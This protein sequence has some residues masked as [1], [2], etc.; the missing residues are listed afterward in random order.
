MDARL[1]RTDV[2]KCTATRTLIA[3]L[4]RCWSD[5][6]FL[7]SLTHRFVRLSLQLIA[8]YSTW[9]RIGLAGDW[10]SVSDAIEN[11][12]ALVIY[13]INMIQKRLPAKLASI[14][15]SRCS[16]LSTDMIEMIENGFLDAVTRYSSVIPDIAESIADALALKCKES[17]Q[18]LRGIVATYRLKSKQAP[19]KHSSFVP[20]ILCP[21]R[22]FVKLNESNLVSSDQSSDIKVSS[23]IAGKVI[24]SVAAEYLT[25]ATE[26][27]EKNKNNEATLRRLNIGRA[28]AANKNKSEAQGMS[29]VE[30]IVL[31]L[32]LD[33]EQFAE[34]VTSVGVDPESIES[35]QKL[36]D[37]IKSEKD[38]TQHQAPCEQQQQHQQSQSQP[39]KVEQ[40][41]E[42]DE[43]I[44]EDASTAAAPSSN[45]VS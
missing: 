43:N 5:D 8:R 21:L 44:N 32:F 31:Q 12:C 1:L 33:V 13:D 19:T 15:R 35:L 30:K 14:L 9:V 36:R 34:E 38:S 37:N 42:Q 17:L 20:Q 29:V 41:Q 6:V 10:L 39:Q 4:R 2:Y 7:L 27:I 25:M 16:S 40:A 22:S 11:N 28:G 3:C 45:S 18:P 24:E 23:N 26:S